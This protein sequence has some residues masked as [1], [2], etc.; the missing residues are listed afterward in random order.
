MAE[1]EE[2]EQWEADREHELYIS[3]TLGLVS[4]VLSD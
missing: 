3:V 4:G 1:S 2:K